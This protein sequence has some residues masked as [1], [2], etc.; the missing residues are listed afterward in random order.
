VLY[1]KHLMGLQGKAG[2]ELHFN[3]TDALSPAQ[4]HYAEA[5]FALFKAWYAGWSGAEG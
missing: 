4:Q 2:Y 5:Q 3:E 1:Y